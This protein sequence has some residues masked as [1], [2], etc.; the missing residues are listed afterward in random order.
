M[1]FAAALSVKS[2]NRSLIPR[3]AANRLHAQSHIATLQRCVEFGLTT[4]KCQ[5][6]LGTRPG[7]EARIAYR[8]RTTV[9]RFPCLSA[10]GPVG[11]DVDI[12]ERDSLH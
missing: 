6:C 2:F 10:T 11:V 12:L 7:L 5:H 9:G 3:S 8:H 1:P 4:A